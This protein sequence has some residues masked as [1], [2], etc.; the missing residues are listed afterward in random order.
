MKVNKLGA[1]STIPNISI[2]YNTIAIKIS[3]RF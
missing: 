3:S 2:E 1:K